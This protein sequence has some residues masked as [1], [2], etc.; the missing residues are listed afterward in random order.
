MAHKP[1]W[2]W[3]FGAGPGGGLGTMHGSIASPAESCGYDAQPNG[4]G[5]LKGREPQGPFSQHPETNS[6]MNTVFRDQLAANASAAG[7]IETP[8]STSGAAL[9]GVRGSDGT[10]G[11]GGGKISSPF[12]SPWGDSAG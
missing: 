1:G 8:M 5:G 3:D 9:P 12:S 10:G 7:G 6:L 11:A 4:G 2:D